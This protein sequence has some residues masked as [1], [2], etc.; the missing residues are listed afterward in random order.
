MMTT[1]R[2]WS[3]VKQFNSSGEEEKEQEQLLP[4]KSE[5]GVNNDIWCHSLVKKGLL[6]IINN[7]LFL[8]PFF[9]STSFDNTII[10]WFNRLLRKTS[11][12]VQHDL[13]ISGEL[14]S[15]GSDSSRLQINKCICSQINVWRTR[16]TCWRYG[17][18]ALSRWTAPCHL[19]W[20]SGSSGIFQRTKWET[21]GQIQ[22]SSTDW[23]RGLQY[24]CLL[25]VH[26]SSNWLRD[27]SQV[28][29]SKSSQIF[30][31]CWRTESEG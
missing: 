27:G 12:E 25:S 23:T 7:N 22:S 28:Y 26:L 21:A 31:L 10:Y 16:W 18:E 15:T 8:F 24:L 19:G 6:E 14:Q 11:K 13:K 17:Q 5:L 4:V 3:S 2:T 9:H 1:V 29:W 20:L 30:C